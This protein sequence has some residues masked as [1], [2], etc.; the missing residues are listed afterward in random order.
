MN[1]ESRSQSDLEF[2]CRYLRR[3]LRAMTF[4]AVYSTQFELG[5]TSEA[6]LGNV[7]IK[8]CDQLNRAIKAPTS[9]ASRRA[10][11]AGR[12]PAMEDSARAVR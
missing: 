6:S 11:A 12:L 3:C 1:P 10:F 4:G 2:S 9:S 7:E 5:P 8:R